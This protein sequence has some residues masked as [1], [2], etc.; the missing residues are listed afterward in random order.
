LT[1]LLIVVPSVYAQNAPDVNT[2][3]LDQLVV[4]I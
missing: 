3:P 1:A 4:K 2:V